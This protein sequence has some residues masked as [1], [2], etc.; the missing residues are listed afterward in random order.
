M[1]NLNLPAVAEVFVKKKELQ[2][3]SII[4]AHCIMLVACSLFFLNAK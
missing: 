4:T 3:T 2:K 1:Y